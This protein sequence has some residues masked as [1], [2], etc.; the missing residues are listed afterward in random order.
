MFNFT[1]RTVRATKQTA[2]KGF[3]A[4]KRSV[5]TL[6]P[7]SSAPATLDPPC[8]I[9]VTFPSEDAQQPAKQPATEHIVWVDCCSAP[10]LPRAPPIREPQL[11]LAGPPPMQFLA[12][13]AGKPTSCL[14]HCCWCANCLDAAILPHALHRDSSNSYTCPQH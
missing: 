3:K 1:K 13:H 6:F 8:K 2:R 4:V 7:C 10:I 14:L 5:R 11:L 9:T 12:W